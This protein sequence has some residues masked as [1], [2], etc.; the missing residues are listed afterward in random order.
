MKSEL[1]AFI[2]INKR[3]ILKFTRQKSR[4]VTDLSRPVIWLL[5]VGYGISTLVKMKN[6]SYMQYIFPGILIMTVLF[7]HID[8]LGQGVR[9]FKRNIGFAGFKKNVC[10]G[11]NYVGRNYKYGSGSYNAGFRPF[12]GNPYYRYF[13]FADCSFF[14]FNIILHYG[15][16][17]SNS[18]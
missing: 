12:F 2:A 10:S 11:K 13:I 6:G 17:H 16:R 14:I 18:I 1:R 7:R 15:F 8:Y 3:E 5:F 9:R 4:L